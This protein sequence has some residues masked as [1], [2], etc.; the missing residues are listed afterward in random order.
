MARSNTATAPST[1]DVK[2]Q[3]D[4]LKG[5]IADLAKLVSQMGSAQAGMAKNTVQE[6]L[7]SARE[8]G[9]AHM[10]DAKA[11]AQKL[12]AEANDFVVRQPAAALGIAA[13]IGF[14]V[15]MLGTRR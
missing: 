7:N 15:G 12:G 2:G 11:Q 10:E 5:D 13:G 9:A 6:Q 14:L 8:A 3:L 1:D 4:T